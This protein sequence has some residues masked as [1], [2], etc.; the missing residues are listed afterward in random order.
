M[1]PMTVPPLSRNTVPPATLPASTDADALRREYE[2]LRA[3][4]AEV[5]RRLDRLAAECRRL[6]DE[7]KAPRG[8]VPPAPIAPPRAEDARSAGG[9][10]GPALRDLIDALVREV[11][12]ARPGS[13]ASRPTR[14]RRPWPWRGL[15][16]ARTGLAWVLAALSLLVLA[17]L[18]VRVAL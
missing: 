5:G 1:P 11:D 6:E 3:Q 8:G 4:V 2:A 9:G 13:T 10:D 15:L 18:A 12:P 17:L 7:K 14:R 16:T